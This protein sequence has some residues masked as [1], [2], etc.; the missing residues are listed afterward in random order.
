MIQRPASGT[1]DLE[2]GKL[3]HAGEKSV[4]FA[5][6]AFFQHLQVHLFSARLRPARASSEGLG[7]LAGSICDLASPLGVTAPSGVALSFSRANEKAPIMSGLFAFWRAQ[8][9]PT[10]WPGFFASL[11]H[12]QE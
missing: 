1:L 7:W 3:T 9:N 8:K 12:T 6:S 10:L 4:A 5:T 11:L 2:L